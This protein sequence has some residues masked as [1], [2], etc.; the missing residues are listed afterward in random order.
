[1]GIA[2]KNCSHPCPI[3]TFGKPT[4]SII[5]LGSSVNA[6][7]DIGKY[8]KRNYVYLTFALI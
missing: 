7:P 2:I 5:I 3:F 8:I 1:M 4:I 6:C